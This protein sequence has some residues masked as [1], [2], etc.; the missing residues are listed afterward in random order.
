MLT[1]AEYAI[2]ANDAYRIV[3]GAPEHGLLYQDNFVQPSGGFTWRSDLTF[4]KFI[5]WLKTEKNCN[6]PENT[7]FAAWTYTNA[8]G[9]TIIAFRGTEAGDPTDKG[10]LL[11]DL[12]LGIGKLPD[13]VRLATLYTQWIASRPNVD[14]SKLTLVGHSLGGAL[15]SAAATYEG[16]PAYVFNP[17]PSRD[18]TET[19]LQGV[20][21]GGLPIDEF[22]NLGIRYFPDIPPAPGVATFA[23]AQSR[24]MTADSNW[25]HRVTVAGELVHQLGNFDY[26]GN[27]HLIDIGSSS[28]VGIVESIGLHSISFTNFVL[29]YENRVTSLCAQVPDLWRELVGDGKKLDGTIWKN[30]ESFYQELMKLDGKGLPS[31]LLNDLEKLVTVGVAGGAGYPLEPQFAIAQLAL[32]FAAKQFENPSSP[33]LSGLFEIGAGTLTADLRRIDSNPSPATLSGLKRLQEIYSMSPMGGVALEDFNAIQKVSFQSD[34][35]VGVSFDG[36]AFNDLLIGGRDTADAF[37]ASEGNDVLAGGTGQGTIDTADY[38]A[39]NGAITLLRRNASSKQNNYVVRKSNGQDLLYS[40]ESVIA[41]RFNDTL[42]GGAGTDI[43]DAGSG[44]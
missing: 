27:E 6:P 42:I 4:E 43:L 19:L 1:A 44:D 36:S 22:G 25:V 34:K 37:I 8:A 35:S 29:A 9:E 17:A 20:S 14:P 7:G 26:I 38:S 41:T 11:A 28:G 3:D 40:L 33:D 16:L 24:V 32:E 13:Q 18:A 12:L 31:A 10:D 2:F 23:D 15:A 5:F 39:Q 21:G 30:G